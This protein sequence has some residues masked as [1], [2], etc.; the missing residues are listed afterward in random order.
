MAPI[1]RANGRM[2]RAFMRMPTWLYRAHLGW[3]LG[4]RFLYIVNRGRKSGKRRHTIVEVVRFDPA[5]PEVVVTASRG[6]R[7]QWYRNLE[8]A[9]AEEVRFGRHRW[10]RPA[11]RFL[12]EAERV[13]VMKGY[14]R[15]HPFAARQ[16][17]RAFGVSDA[18]D[19][20]VREIAEQLR[21]V[22]FSPSA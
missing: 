15:E 2:A 13:E 12:E 14:A 9:P 17:G 18:D 19:A 1:E 8:A 3:L 20:G 11:Q 16:L 21:A 6:P 22:A 7:T 4:S 5:V 10:R